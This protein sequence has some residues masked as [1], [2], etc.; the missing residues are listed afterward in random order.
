MSQNPHL[1]IRNVTRQFHVNGESL[2]ALD[3]VSLDVAKGEFVTIVG[4]SGCGKS[5]LLRL[6][7]GLD[8]TYSGAITHA[9]KPVDGP[10]LDRGMVFQEPRLFPWLTIERN[11][12]LGLENSGLGKG[13]KK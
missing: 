11:V 2:T 13:E 7:A 9:G 4:A 8:T 5:T 6:G 1:E 3:T 10:S 12:A